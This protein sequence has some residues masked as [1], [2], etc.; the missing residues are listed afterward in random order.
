M[1]GPRSSSRYSQPAAGL[2]G[3]DRADSAGSSESLNLCAELGQLHTASGSA[4]IEID[5]QRRA[6]PIFH[7]QEG[8]GGTDQHGL[9]RATVQW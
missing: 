8:V 4:H 5:G 7:Q 6:S 1:R 9:G 2:S 3:D